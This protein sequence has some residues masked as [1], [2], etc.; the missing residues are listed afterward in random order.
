MMVAAVSS[1]KLSGSYTVVDYRIRP[2][3]Y[4][5]R[6]MI[7]EAALRLRFVDLH[8]YRYVGMGSIYF[9]DFKLIHRTLGI[10]DMISIE[11]RED[12]ENRF[13]WNRPYDSISMKFG[14]TGAVLP[15]LDWSIPSV[16][17]L[18]YDGQLTSGKLED[19]DYL[20]RVSKSGSMLVFSVNAEKPA[21]EGMSR[22]K[23]EADL[24]GALKQLVGAHRVD[25]KIKQT[26][27]TGAQAAKTYYKIISAAIESSIAKSNALIKDD[28]QKIIWKQILH[29]VYKDGASMLT[30]G[31]IVIKQSDIAV[32]ESGEFQRLS[33]FRDDANPYRIE[34]PKLT[35]KEMSF[36]AQSA[37]DDPKLCNS[38][39]WLE[40]KDRTT[41]LKLFRYLP[42]FVAAES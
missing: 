32:Y 9:S 18:D 17:W 37:L 31:G 11:G 22:E 24:P 38:L 26:D 23:R 36:L 15:S 35:T 40:P 19:I 29:V 3:K 42:N 28:S 30:V 33:F 8:D 10:S 4:A 7:T 20:L 41:F 12:E 6:L 34:V 39:E 27:L 5:E 2:A 14:M 21:P 13:S 16:V 1:E 25:S